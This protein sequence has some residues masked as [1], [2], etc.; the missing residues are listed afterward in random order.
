MKQRVRRSKL[1][2]GCLGASSPGKLLRARCPWSVGLR[3]FF[4]GGRKQAALVQSVHSLQTVI[5]L[6]CLQTTYFQRMHQWNSC[7]HHH[8][9]HD[10]SG[11]RTASCVDLGDNPIP[12]SL[13]NSR[14]DFGLAPTSSLF[15]DHC[16]FLINATLS[17]NLIL[18][19]HRALKPF[20]CQAVT[21]PRVSSTE[22]SWELRPS[23]YKHSQLCKNTHRVTRAW[24]QTTSAHISIWSTCVP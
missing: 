20:V 4:W 21:S 17:N 7:Q 19:C 23:L 12:S 16:N 18:S 8:L 9:K 2:K 15:F 13:F 1:E 5:T 14:S 3:V 10:V 6:S 11:Q 22:H 24:L